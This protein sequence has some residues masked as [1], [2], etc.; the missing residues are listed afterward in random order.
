M[1]NVR[2]KRKKKTFLSGGSAQTCTAIFFSTLRSL[3][4]LRVDQCFQL[5]PDLMVF[6]PETRGKLQVCNFQL[7]RL[8]QDVEFVNMPVVYSRLVAGAK[9]CTQTEKE[10]EGVQQHTSV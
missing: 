3:I 5:N 4:E 9:P 7:H 1:I 2:L 10:Q 6:K 8:Q